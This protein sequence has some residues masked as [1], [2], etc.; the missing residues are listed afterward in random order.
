[1]AKDFRTLKLEIL[2][3]TKNF[4]AG[5]NEGE[6]KTQSFGDKLG[7]F[8]KKAGLALA[9]ATAAVGAF[10]IKIAVD[11]VKAASDLSESVSKVGV[12]FGDSA[13]KIEAFAESAAASLGQTKQQALDAASTFAIFG[14]S[15]GLAGDDLVKFST[16]FTTLASDLASFNNTSPEDAIQAI[17]AA[18]R[19]ETEPLRRYGVLL[20]D[21]SLRQA[22]LSLGIIRTTKEA[23]T[24]QQKVLAA[25]E[26]IYQQTSAAQG[27]F[28]R[29]SDGLANSQRILN[30][31]L[32]NIRTEIG[33]ALLPIVLKLT[34][35]FTNNVLPVIQGVA[36]AFSS[37]AGGLGEGLFQFVDGVK[38]FLLPI[39]DGAINAF[40]DIKGAIKE[41]IDEFE[42]FFNVVKSL[43]PIIG[44]TIGAAL[45]VVGDIAAV[46]IN[47]ISNVLGVISGIVNKAID[48]INVIIRAV[49]RIPGVNIPQIGGVGSSGGGTAGATGT[50]FSQLS[51]LGQGVAGA[52]A[53]GGFS[54]SGF[55]NLPS[56][57]SRENQERLD[58]AFV[59][60]YNASRA[61]AGVGSGGTGVLGATGALDLVKR[62]TSVDNAFT[63]LTFQ[64]KTNGI[65]QK[66]A[67]AQFDKLTAEFA[68]LERQAGALVPT[69]V[70]LGATPFG[71][72]GGNTTNIYV[73]GAI[74][75]ERTAR[76]IATTLNSQAARSVTAL[77]DRV[78]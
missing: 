68:V 7:E 12:L 35:I 11:G 28:Q 77:R 24:P 22:A 8:G 72:A 49:N 3:E 1:M 45:N 34:Q 69:P 5:M 20:D 18:L 78:N 19:G 59:E 54:G 50:G 61:A 31:Q 67:A 75:P 36:D 38:L 30:A 65:S 57:G 52:V 53:A 44:T 70:P 48:A 39:I 76:D 40:N 47:V 64:V 17:G 15:A 33:E 25:Q 2:A 27:D 43:A 23:L 66:A 58:K 41:N 62:L 6:K 16:D 37:K 21:A 56:G 13:S 46:V 73:T 42:S 63:D 51:G 74:D 29:T 55:S 4:I 32:A 71:Q 26:L 14:S 9:A 10:A 60:S